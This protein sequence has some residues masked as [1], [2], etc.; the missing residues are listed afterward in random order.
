[1]LP[2]QASAKPP[3][4][5]VVHQGA[6]GAPAYTEALLQELFLQGQ[7]TAAAFAPGLSA[8]LVAAQLA[9]RGEFPM[10]ALEHGHSSARAPAHCILCYSTAG[11]LQGP[12]FT[13]QNL[14]F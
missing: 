11:I 13:S 14:S 4:L 6:A 3:L 8:A 5:Q 9:G 2:T 1:M 12:R 7:S 10:A